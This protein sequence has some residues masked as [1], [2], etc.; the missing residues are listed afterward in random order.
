[1]AP[2]AESLKALLTTFL[3]RQAT[4]TRHAKDSQ[5]RRRNPVDAQL[6]AACAE[7]WRL[8]SEELDAALALRERQETAEPPQESLVETLKHARSLMAETSRDIGAWVGPIDP[9]LP[10]EIADINSLNERLWRLRNYADR[11]DRCIDN[12]IDPSLVAH[13]EGPATAAPVESEGVYKIGEGFIPIDRAYEELRA[14]LCGDE[15]CRHDDALSRAKRAAHD[16]ALL[17]GQ[18]EAAAHREGRPPAAEKLK[19]DD[20][21]LSR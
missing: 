16:S 14:A 8:A 9:P 18:F 13:R 12:Y 19:N 7:D 4:F 6:A 21:A 15:D 3:E 20:D 1:M 2:T 10:A 11:L 5:T 17:D